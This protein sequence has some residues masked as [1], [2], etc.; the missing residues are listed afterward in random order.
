MPKGYW[1]VSVDVSDPEGYKLYIAET[2]NASRKFG[3]RYLARGGKAEVVE[4]QGRS[5]IVIMEFKDFATALAC[6]HSP[7]YAKAISMRE[8][9][10]IADIIITEGCEE[11]R[12]ANRT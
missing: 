3:A 6:Y 5:R 9:K 1:V 12:D 10:A 4:G 7:E 8:G 11:P 2:A